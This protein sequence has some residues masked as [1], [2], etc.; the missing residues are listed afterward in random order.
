MRFWPTGIGRKFQRQ[1]TF[2]EKDTQLSA[3][4]FRVGNSVVATELSQISIDISRYLRCRV[5]EGGP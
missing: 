2:H 1:K 5:W 4:Y 3:L